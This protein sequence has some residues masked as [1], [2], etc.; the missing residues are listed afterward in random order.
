MFALNEPTVYNLKV[1][2]SRHIAGWRFQK[3]VHD[4][5]SD[6]KGH[7]ERYHIA[8]L[9]NRGL[10]SC[11]S[12]HVE[13]GVYILETSLEIPDTFLV[14]RIRVR[15]VIEYI[16]LDG[17]IVFTKPNRPS[18]LGNEE[19]PSDS[20]FVRSIVT[21]RLDNVHAVTEDRV[22][23]IFIIVTEDKQRRATEDNALERRYSCE[24]QESRYAEAEL[25][26]VH[27]P[28]QRGVLQGQTV[29]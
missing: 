19:L 10:C 29:G 3:V 11:Q 24:I 12:R 7:F 9:Q 8:G 25:A 23:E 13:F 14:S 27:G 22:H 18:H 6:S 15:D 2:V 1:H 28:E 26:D 5:P 20:A 21:F 4:L 17:D 16:V